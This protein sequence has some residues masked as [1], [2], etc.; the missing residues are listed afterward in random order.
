MNFKACRSIAF[1]IFVVNFT[2]FAQLSDSCKLE[3]G[4]NLGGLADYGTELPFVD[5]MHSCRQWYS[6]DVANSSFDSG[7]ADSLTYRP[8]G[9]PTHLPQTANGVALR[10]KVATIW[11]GTDSWPAGTYTVL[12]DG[13]GQLSLGG[14]ISNVTQANAHKITFDYAVQT[15]N[16]IELV[17]DSSLVTNPIRN[18]RVL[19][20][21]TEFTYMTQPF[22]PVWIN[23]LSIFKSVRFMDWFQ[24]NGWGQPDTYSWEDARLFNWNERAQLNHYTWANNKGVP[25]EMAI[26]LMNDYDLDG[27]VCVPHRASNQF[28]D[29]M[30]TLF[31]TRVEPQ[32]KI[33]VEFSNE[34][35]NW[36]FGQTQWLN[37]YGCVDRGVSWPEGIA[38]YVENCLQ[39]WTTVFSG[40]LNRL[41][42]TCAVQTAW[43]DVS[44]RI[45]FNVSRPLLDAFS[46]AYYFGLGERADSTL[47]VLGAT[48]TAADV[49]RWVRYTRERD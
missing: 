39:R 14:G 37:K 48:A 27:W 43:Q 36:M 30:A 15:G 44:N 16:Y 12:Y 45:I 4:T 8:D 3:I 9:Y 46:P 19:M 17:L 21:N 29:S 40:Q 10:Q 20:P 7:V 41:V 35:W 32:R 26:K 13:T 11:V 1:L 18:I 24:T 38:P 22:N 33:T 34:N 42:R 49:A 2:A 31:K 47:D 5:L 25:Y 28:I 23:K 6:K